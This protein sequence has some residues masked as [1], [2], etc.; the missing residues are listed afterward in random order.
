MKKLNEKALDAAERVASLIRY[1]TISFRALAIDLI[2]A[3]LDA[4]PNVEVTEEM[5]QRFSERLA[6]G[7]R[8]HLYRRENL[9][10]ALRWFVST[11]RVTPPAPQLPDGLAAFFAKHPLPWKLRPFV[12]GIFDS[13]NVLV[14]ACH[15]ELCKVV[16]DAAAPPFEPGPYWCKGTDG[17]IEP[18][19][20]SIASAEI[21]ERLQ[22]Q[23]FTIGPRAVP[24]KEF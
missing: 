1:N 18:H 15:V 2:T 7:G 12:H 10:E 21:A 6:M 13:N 22:S 8:E 19:P 3:Y 4:L 24:P 14:A 20:R 11:Y 9:A 17:R 23:G 16:N 5:A